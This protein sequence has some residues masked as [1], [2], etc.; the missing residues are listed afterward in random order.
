M[1]MLV[2]YRER[3]NW[4]KVKEREEQITKEREHWEKEE[5]MRMMHQQLEILQKL[6]V[7]RSKREVK[8]S[9]MEQLKLTKLTDQND[10]EPFLMTFERMMGCSK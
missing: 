2:E 6:V 4:Q 1:K 9:A 3:K 8:K 7:V 5:K 10:I